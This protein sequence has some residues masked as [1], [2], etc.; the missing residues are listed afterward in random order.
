MSSAAR[1]S[2]ARFTV[3]QLRMEAARR[4]GAE[5]ISLD[6]ETT[7]LH[8][9]TLG[10]QTRVLL[11]GISP[12]N[13]AA[14]HRLAADKFHTAT[15]LARAGLA[16]PEGVRCL[17]TGRFD[18]YEDQTGHQPGLAFAAARG[19]PLVVKPNGGSR[20]R[21]VTV[22][23]SDAALT[24]AIDGAWTDDYLA[25]V[26]VP[27]KGIDLRVDMLDGRCVFAYQRL[28]LAIEGDGRRTVSELLAAVDPRFSAHWC[29]TQLPVQ[30]QWQ[31]VAA[32]RTLEP[33]SVLAA[34]DRL[35]FDPVVLNL[36]RLCAW[37]V[38][39]DMP[40]AWLTLCQR[41][42]SVM[43]LRHCGIDFKVPSFTEVPDGAVVIEVNASP[44]LAN[45]SRLGH[46][47]RVIAVEQQIVAAAFGIVVEG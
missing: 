46:Y 6:P 38:V 22:V 18:D 19:Y 43:G 7:Y 26:Q 1:D 37:K 20:G 4:L 27:V 21:G 16:V 41:V 24:R 42:A 15:V 39:T 40:R 17:R 30:P 14:T 47:E 3:V 44:S 29:A 36:N 13:D 25:L 12:L 33:D 11:G 23:D 8:E 34:G 9:V 10:G 5:V 35:D 2:D 45:M 31:E 32:A 28:A